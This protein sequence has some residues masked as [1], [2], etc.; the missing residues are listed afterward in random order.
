[1]TV[2]FHLKV[3]ENSRSGCYDGGKQTNKQKN[4]R[5]G[6][7]L[8]DHECGIGISSIFDTVFRYLPI[9]LTVLRYWVAPNVPFLT[10][11]S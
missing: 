1:M 6:Y 11:H 8:T 2:T 9:F 4:T 7:S 10:W 5:D 3:E